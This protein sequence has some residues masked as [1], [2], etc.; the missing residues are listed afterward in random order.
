MDIKLIH[1]SI[2]DNLVLDALNRRNKFIWKIILKTMILKTII[3]NNDSHLI[4]GIKER[5]K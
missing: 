1:K 3:W 4:N 5:Y 2:K